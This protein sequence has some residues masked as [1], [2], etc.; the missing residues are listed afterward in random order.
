[1]LITAFTIYKS[2]LKLAVF[3]VA[4]V[5]PSVEGETHRQG[6]LCFTCD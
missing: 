3:H 5:I 6:V 1:L 2:L 4:S